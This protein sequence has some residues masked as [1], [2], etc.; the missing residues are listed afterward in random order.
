[1]LRACPHHGFTEL[2]QIDTFYNGLN[3]N[4]QDSL[5]AAAG[6]NLL[7]KTTR[8][9]LNIIENKSKVRY[10]RNKSNVSRVN[11]TSKENAS[12]TDDMIDKL[13]D[14]ISTLVEIVS[15]KVVTL[16]TMKAVEESCVICG[17]PH[18]YYNCITTNSNQ[19]SV[20]TTMST[21]KQVAP[22]NHASNH[23]AP[24]GFA[25]VQN[26]SQN[27]YNQ[28]QG[29][30]NSFNR[31]NNFHRNQSFQ[32]Q[33]NHAPNFQNQGFQNQPFQVPS[34][35]VQQGFL[36]EFSN[37]MKS[38]DQMMRNMQN[39]I[40]SLKGDFKN[41]I[42][43]TMKNKQTVLMNQQNDFQN[44][45][46]NMLRPKKVLVPSTS[47]TLPSNTISN[48]K[49]E[50]KAIT[51]RSGVAYEGPLILTNPSPKKDKLFELAKISLNENYSEM[52]LKMIP[53]KLGDPSKFLIPY[54][55]ITRP[56]GVAEDVFVKVGKFH[57]PTDFVVVDFE[58]DPQ[59]ND[60]PFQL[61]PMD[62]KQGEVAMEKSS[63]EEP[64]ELELKDLPLH[65][66]YAYLEGADKLP[67]SPIHCVPKKCGIT[68]V[69]NENN[70]LIPTRLVM[71]WRVCID[72]RKLNDA[73][74]K[75]HFPL[76]FMDQMLERLAGNEFYC[77]LGG[78]SGYFQIS[79]NPP[80]KE[81]TTFTCPYGTF[82][83]Q[84]MPFGLC[85]DPRTFQR[86]MMVIFHDMI[87][88]TMEVFMDDFL[89]FEDSFSSCLSHLDTMLQRLEV[90]RAKVDVITK[91]PHPTTVKGVRSFLGHV[92]FYR[93]FIQDFSKIARPMTHLL[94]KETPFGFSKDCIDA[95]ETLKKKL[96]EVPILVVPDWNLPFE[97]MC[98]ASDFAIGA[99]LGQRK[100]KHFQPIHYASKTL[101]EAQIHYTTTEKE[102]LAVVYAFEKFR[103]YLVLSK[104]IVYTDHSALKY[105]L[106]KQISS[107]D[108]SGGFST[109]KNLISLSVIRKGRRISRQ[110]ICLDL[111]ILIR[112]ACHKG[113]TGGHHG[114]NFTSKKVFDAGFFW[115]TIYRDAHNLVK[116]CYSCQRKGKISQ[117]DEMPQNVIQV[118]KSFDV[119]G[120]DFMGPFP[121]SRGNRNVSNTNNANNQRGTELG[122][123][124]TCYECGVKGHYKRDCPKLKNNNNQGNQ[125]GRNNASAR[126]YAVGR[127]G[128]DPDANVVTGTFLLNNRYASILFDTG[129]DRSFVSTTFST[130]INITPSTLDH[131]YDVELADE[132]T[133]GLNTILRSYTLNHL[134]HP[135]S[136]D[137]MP[138]ELGSFDVIIGM[139]WLASKYVVPTGRAVPAGRDVP[140]GRV[141]PA[142]KV[143]P[144]GRACPHHGFFEL[145]QL[146]TFYNALNITDQDLLNS[147]ASG[148]F[149]DKMPRECLKI[150]E[151]KSRV[152]QSQSKA[153]V[154]KVSTRSSTHAVSFDVAELKDMVRA[155]LLD[156]KNQAPA[157]A[158]IKA[159][160]Q[161]CAPALQ[162]PGVSK[163]V[164][165][166]YV[167][168]NDAVIRN[169]Q[170]Q[171]Q[172]MQNQLTNLTDMLLKFVNANTASSS[173]SGTLPSNTVTYPKEDLKGITTRSGAAYQGPTIPFFSF[174]TL[175][176]VVN[177][178]TE[179]TK[180]TVLPTNNGGTE[181]IHPSVVQ[182]FE[183]FVAPGLTHATPWPILARINLMPHSVWKDLYLPELTPTCMTLE[184][185]DQ[186][187]T[188]PIGIAK[189]V[190]VT[191]E[192]FQFP[193]DFVVVDFE[194]DPRVPLIL[195]RSF[196]KTS[197]ALIDVYQGEI[198]LRVGKEAITFNL[199]QTS[200]Y[201]ANYDHM[202]VNRVD[203]IDMAYEEYSQKVLSFLNVITS[204]NPTPNFD[205]IVSTSSPTLTPFGDS[206]FSFLR[207]PTLFLLLKM[208][209][210]YRK[211]TFFFLKKFSIVIPKTVKSS[212]DEPP[213][214]ELKD[215]P[216]HLEYTFLEGDDKL[217]VI[218]AR[219]LK[220]E[221]KDALMK[222][223]IDPKD[224]E[225]ITFTSPYETFAYRRMP[226]GLC[227]APDTFQRCMIAIFYDM[228]EKTMEV[229]MDDFSVFRDS[230]STCLSHLEKY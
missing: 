157:P 193:A 133:I 36:N 78:F 30:G 110:T 50:M 198:T 225:K 35:Q 202:M 227:N 170:T 61:P 14:Q 46:Q 115:P 84:R 87:E 152:H 124:P 52:L 26:I 150:I 218:I 93:R 197:R 148:N 154:A 74:R 105:L 183:P 229:F 160:E 215:L 106:S 11:T 44:N 55:S 142:G 176:K 189:D 187:I 207:K 126:V 53:E 9:A 174:S 5:N 175:P 71:G 91:L 104:S 51:T 200:R 57:F 75:D 194:P 171:G 86:C 25:P 112:I 131:C 144:A 120:I 82:A 17:G 145:H 163:T 109:Y 29:Q 22:Q 85:N 162:A 107:R 95:F 21:Y 83:Y 205:P 79:I 139:D 226:F 88:K 147:A 15:E 181:V 166:S 182:N 117:R 119:R 135:F 16:A 168:A 201:I 204:G 216:P 223:P 64:P 123:K 97:L 185:A 81:N 54:R 212:I 20:C 18:A 221:E 177:R 8:E 33:I 41:E 156:K 31:G 224:Q 62:L 73:T 27:R 122:Q 3:E 80:D 192:K 203:V 125:G 2:I 70:E 45:L 161:S 90:D 167:K 169:V 89:V 219:D 188:E 13:A 47:G 43:N 151:S 178:E 76:L 158:T 228:I 210:L 146:D 153:V 114:A 102:I 191:V 143:V 101:T 206:V 94:E 129:A 19:S 68:V 130:Q 58:A 141:V 118:C 60:D 10:L 63:I 39:Q 222:I 77:F 34:N 4:D 138:L 6:G 23:M 220:D 137:L 98:D 116:S 213:E 113:P 186:S 217:P 40:N 140:A 196:L 1:M 65:L 159:V 38:N 184:L 42:Q 24:P 136:I 149:L 128:T 208:I 67:V 134:N 28:N 56:K 59:L 190:Y 103:P 37:Y 69:E 155:L 12:K 49:G 211:G 230:F 127:T 100:T 209:L 121:S 199:D 92:G 72:Y 66:E 108:C 48:P 195:G 179:V 180:D 164:F 7:S 214:V 172:T 165:E 99:V 173:G 32:G 111:R 96:T 132:R